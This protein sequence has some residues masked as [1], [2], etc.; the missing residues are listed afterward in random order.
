M[1]TKFFTI[2]GLTAAIISIAPAAKALEMQPTL[3]EQRLSVLDR[4]GAKAIEDIH[5]T[6]LYELDNRNKVV[7]D[8]HATRLYELN[9]RSKGNDDRLEHLN[10]QTVETVLPSD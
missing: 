9:N 6:R 4:G 7:E 10:N 1:N 2:L 5:A 8:I 3:Q